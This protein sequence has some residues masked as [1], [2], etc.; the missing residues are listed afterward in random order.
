MNDPII[1]KSMDSLVALTHADKHAHAHATLSK[2][3]SIVR[4]NIRTE[5]AELKASGLKFFFLSWSVY[6]YKYFTLLFHT[7][8]VLKQGL[9]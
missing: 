6:I 3:S 1:N 9:A 4:V 7:A 2:P 8:L 5:Q